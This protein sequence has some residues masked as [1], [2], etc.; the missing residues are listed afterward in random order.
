M[1]Q[2][3][4]LHK[5]FSAYLESLAKYSM[6][7]YSHCDGTSSQHSY[8]TIGRDIIQSFGNEHIIYKNVL[9][10]KYPVLPCRKVSVLRN[11]RLE[12]RVTQ[13]FGRAR[14]GNKKVSLT[15]FDHLL[16]LRFRE[17][18]VWFTNKLVRPFS[19]PLFFLWYQLPANQFRNRFLVPLSLYIAI[20]KNSTGHLRKLS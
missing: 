8:Y 2:Y 11:S 20:Y 12:A 4:I 16:P 13:C 1:A 7:E 17:L 15:E 3:F 10:T 19:T 14:W 9:K 5:M 6:W 18:I